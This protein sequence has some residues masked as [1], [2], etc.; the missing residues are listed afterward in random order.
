MNS[1]RRFFGAAFLALVLVMGLIAA[2][3]GYNIGS[4]G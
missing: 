3:V 4:Y 1:F 2:A